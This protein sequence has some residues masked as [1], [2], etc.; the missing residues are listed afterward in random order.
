MSRDNIDPY[1]SVVSV[2]SKY[3]LLNRKKLSERRTQ[4]LKQSLIKLEALVAV[5][6]DDKRER[7]ETNFNNFENKL[8]REFSRLI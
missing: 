5:L 8:D 1:K 6:K 4:S 7:P 3:Q 2:K